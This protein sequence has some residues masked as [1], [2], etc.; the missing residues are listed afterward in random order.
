MT[1]RPFGGT[2]NDF[3]F[4]VSLDGHVL[5]DPDVTCNF[6]TA[7]VNGTHLTDLLDINN[8]AVTF[9]TSDASGQI[10]PFQGPN[11]GVAVMWVDAGGPTRQRIT[12]TDMD[13]ATQLATFASINPGPVI[14]PLTGMFHAANFGA[15][16]D[17]SHDDTTAIQAAIDAAAT[18]A[19]GTGIGGT[20]YLNGL[21]FLIS[22]PLIL[23]KH[24]ML[25]GAGMTATTIKLAVNANC[26][27]IKSFAPAT[28]T[29]TNADFVAIKDLS[30]DGNRT[31]Q[32][33]A[34]PYYG[35]NFTT[36]PLTST[37][38]AD[39]FFDMHHTLD[40]VRV[41]RA[42]DDGFH[43]AGRSAIQVINCFA[44]QCNGY[45]FF[46]TFD[47]NFTHCESDS[48]GKAGFY[49]NNGSIRLAACKSYL[50]GQV[51]TTSPG[52]YLDSGA[53]GIGLSACE[54]Q[55]NQGAGFYFNGCS[56]VAGSGLVADSNNVIN[57]GYPGFDFNGA[58]YCV[59]DGVA[60]QGLQ[61]GTRV[62][63]QD[64]ALR[65]G[66]TANYNDI[67]LS[68]SPGAGTTI[69]GIY[70]TG[71]TLLANRVFVNGAAAVP[72]A[73]TQVQLAPTVTGLSASG[74]TLTATFATAPT[75]GNLMV[76]Y[77]AG[78]P[79]ASG[80]PSI[81]SGWTLGPSAYFGGDMCYIAYRKVQAGDGS[82]YTFG[83]STIGAQSRELAME[84]LAG[85]ATGTLD[86]SAG[87]SSGYS[88]T[89]PS[90][91]T[92]AAITYVVAI[93]E[94]TGVSAV[95][96]SSAGATAISFTLGFHFQDQSNSGLTQASG[97]TA[98]TGTYAATFAASGVTCIAA[99]K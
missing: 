58:N 79:T 37:A 30:L 14:N 81:P 45:G 15:V 12:S 72:P 27:V 5:A 10:P 96:P 28:S 59:I 44:Q 92:T 85:L 21:Y 54:A 8:N 50:S 84:E 19:A 99:F 64:N 62:G 20:V 4:L 43:F 32:S 80:T 29:G 55:N 24:V 16:G 26:D 87:N 95:A 11:T 33:G 93:L 3:V 39:S 90:L 91:T 97:V 66:G 78:W 88:A 46:S 73:V 23:K 40:N 71:S 38:S 51:V 63:A 52:Y 75:V 47:T 76:A 22:A 68:H 6:Y 31:N 65:L 49:L 13:A 1:R 18:N 57:G 17:G 61:G 74:T 67:R 89:T 94:K 9:I 83:Y 69:G 25:R 77:F 41:Y 53:S 56:R 82:A 42:Q 2:T 48:A 35:V 7:A 34:G 70:A 98:T 36:N 86:Q 60:W